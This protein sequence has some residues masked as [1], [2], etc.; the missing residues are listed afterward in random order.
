M[1]CPVCNVELRLAEVQ[2]EKAGYAT[3]YQSSR[4]F[5]FFCP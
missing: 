1:L 5:R 3:T 4:I 2:R